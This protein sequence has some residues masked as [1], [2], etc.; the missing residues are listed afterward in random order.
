MLC[1]CKL[2]LAYIVK[3]RQFNADLYFEVEHL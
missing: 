2:G 3:R 1:K